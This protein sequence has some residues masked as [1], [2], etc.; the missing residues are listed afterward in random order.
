MI[1]IYLFFQSLILHG[2]VNLVPNPSFEEYS[3]CPDDKSQIDRTMG[4][5][6][7]N[8]GSPDYY[9]RCSSDPKAPSSVPIH[10]SIYTKSPYEGKAYIGLGLYS[11]DLDTYIREYASIELENPLIDK[12]IYFARFKVSPID[13]IPNVNIPCFIDKIGMNFSILLTPEISFPN[14]PINKQKYF[15]NEMNIL[16]KINEWTSISNCLV[17]GRE[18]FITIGNFFE[19]GV[20]LTNKECFDFF[21]NGAYYYI[22]DVGVYEFDPLPDTLLLCEGESREIGQKFL[23]GMYQWNTGS[24]DSTIV[25]SESGTYIIDVDMGSCI[26]SDTVVVI[27]MSDLDA[28]LPQDTTICV[29]TKFKV[30]IPSLGQILW[31]TGSSHS[32]IS[33]S[34]AGF[35][36]V[37]IDNQCGTFNHSF[38]V[39]TQQ[40]DCQVITPNIISPNDDGV[41]DEMLFYMDCLYQFNI[42]TIRIYDRWGSLVFQEKQVNDNK[43]V[44]NGKINGIELSTGVY[45]WVI[46]YSYIDNGRQISKIKSG[47]VTIIH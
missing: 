21:P 32:T 46:N 24:Q 7:P 9:N 44:W 5:F 29:G 11:K 23:D 37:Q 12:K 8:N 43:I 1:F 17:G 31:N 25:V 6:S 38:D 10:N 20:T 47:N 40:C 41:N 19:N 3:L 34:E 45:C 14:K 22:D 30:E 27:N 13:S 26:L 36:N 28:Y 16:N 15:G 33:I 2:Q 18:K 42:N 35:Y 39:M 4:W